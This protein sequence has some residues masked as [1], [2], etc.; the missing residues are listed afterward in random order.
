MSKGSGETGTTS[1]IEMVKANLVAARTYAYL[2][3]GSIRSLTY[4][5]VHTISCIWV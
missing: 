2:A 4:W 3:K 5:A 1:P